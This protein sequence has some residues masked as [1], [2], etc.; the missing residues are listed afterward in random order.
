MRSFDDDWKLL[1]A[2]GDWLEERDYALAE[3][4]GPEAMSSGLHRYARPQTSILITADRGQWFIEVQP[5][6][7]SGDWFNLE[8]WSVCLGE[9]VSFHDM[10]PRFSDQDWLDGIA[11]SWRLEPQVRYLRAHLDEIEAA[12]EPARL[13][14]TIECLVAQTER[15]RV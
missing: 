4:R 9:A 14:Q 15:S 5:D 3:S 2:T 8:N 7:D 11:N 13:E 6:Q 12:C 10:R 1:E